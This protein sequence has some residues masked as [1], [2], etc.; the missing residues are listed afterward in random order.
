MATILRAVYAYLFLLLVLRLIGRRA[1]MQ[2]SPFE[3]ILIFLFGGTMIQAVVGD[4]RSMVNASLVVM[5]IG[6]MHA[7]VAY[8]KFRFRPFRKLVEGTAIVMH[9]RGEPDE[10]RMRR[11]RL[12]IDDV[13][14]AARSRGIQRLED[15]DYVVFERSG[16]LSVIE[17]QA[18][19]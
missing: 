18:P 14:A 6:L 2:N 1:I 3:L 5:T 8:L 17:K 10:V 13:M 19:T 12:Q 9:S 16:A 4:D 7:L 15:I 11:S